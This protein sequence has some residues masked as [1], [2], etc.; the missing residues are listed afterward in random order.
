[1]KRKQMW[2]LGG[3]LVAIVAIALV[4][5]RGEKGQP[6]QAAAVAREN[7]QAKVSA[8]GKIQ[9]VK[10]VDIT[11]NVM[12]PVTQL[13]VKEGAL[14]KKGD[15]LLEIDPI[16]SRAAVQGLEAALRAM[17][18]DSA[19]ANIK[20]AQVR[21]DFL[22]AEA[23]RK[24]GIISQAD[25][26]QARTLLDTAETAAKSAQQ[27]VDQAKADRAGAKDTLD[28]TRITA[29]M[30][31]VV[32][33]KRI[34]LGE[35]AVIGL[36]SQAGTVLVTVSDMSKVEAEMEVDEASIPSVKVDQEAQVRIDAYPNQVFDGVVTEVGGSPIVKLT[37]NEATKFKVKIQ[38][39]NPPATIKP[40]FS[41]QADIF[42]GRRDQV[43]AVPLQALVLKEIKAKPGQPLK[44]GAPR[45]EEGVF[46]IVDG[47][48]RFLPVKTGLVGEL[49]IEVLSG[50][51]GGEML[52]TGPFKALRELKGDELVRVEKKPKK[53][54]DKKAE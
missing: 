39:K 45:D 16:R 24:A 51:K 49:T 53:T 25:F 1:M 2:I 21:K 27:R 37:T 32:T 40:G 38:I 20:L 26:E 8:N 52:I 46:V 5:G 22:R 54:D 34:E 15:L 48:A 50:L 42:T 13:T 29:P 43:L 33:A 14:V 10:K 4:A 17:T 19:T 11:A 23:N 31:G 47:K 36:Q 12:G 41:A 28:K 18:H 44:P 7:I 30:D 9:A 35:T 3:G 6:V